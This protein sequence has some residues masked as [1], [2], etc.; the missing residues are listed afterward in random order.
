MICDH[1]TDTSD[2]IE[3]PFFYSPVADLND[4]LE[5]FH[6]WLTDVAKADSA[7]CGVNE[8]ATCH[9]R[10]WWKPSKTWRLPP[11]NRSMS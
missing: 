1:I 9:R 2:A 6:N 3:K 7:N 8:A 4:A 11:P 5:R 10:S